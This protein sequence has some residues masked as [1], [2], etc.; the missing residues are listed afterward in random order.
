MGANIVQR[1]SLGEMI[2]PTSIETKCII[3]ERHTSGRSLQLFVLYCLGYGFLLLLFLRPSNLVR[4]FCFGSRWSTRSALGWSPAGFS[5]RRLRMS[6]MAMATALFNYGSTYACLCGS[7]S[8]PFLC[9]TRPLNHVRALSLS[10]AFSF[11]KPSTP[12]RALPTC[13]DARFISSCR[14]SSRRDNWEALGILFIQQ[15]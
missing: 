4:L 1:R 14:R 11:W 12:L 8:T 13:S 2:L 15:S 6:A 3:F 5:Y 10:E 7:S 9:S